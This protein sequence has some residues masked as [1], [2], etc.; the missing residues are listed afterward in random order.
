MNIIADFPPTPQKR[1]RVTRFVTF[2]PSKKDKVAFLKTIFNQ[3]PQTPSTKPLKID[4]TF[5]FEHAKSHLKKNGELKPYA[6]KLHTQRPDIDNLVKFVLDAL[7]G[8]L[9]VDDS[10]IIELSAIKKFAPEACIE[11]KVIEFTE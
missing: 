1:P 7:N 6:P 11:I 9:Y 8:H 3:L 2:D 5:N 10:Q 4:I